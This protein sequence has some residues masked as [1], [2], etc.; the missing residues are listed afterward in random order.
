ME[1]PE[2]QEK[3]LLA[4]QEKQVQLVQ[5]VKQ[6]QLVVQAQME[7]LEVQVPQ[8]IQVPLALNLLIIKDYGVVLQCMALMMP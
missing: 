6:E 8:A 2:P 1:Q 3:V 4:Q 5:Q 7:Q